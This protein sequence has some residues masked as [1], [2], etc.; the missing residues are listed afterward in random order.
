MG[1]SFTNIQKMIEDFEEGQFGQY[2]DLEI[3]IEHLREENNEMDAN[4]AFLLFLHELSKER[5][6][7]NLEK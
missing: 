2:F 3:L 6:L 1:I 4:E 5:K 7:K